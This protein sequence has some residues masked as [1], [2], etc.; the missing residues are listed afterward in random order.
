MSDD[1]SNDAAKGRMNDY[2]DGPARQESFA[3]RADLGFE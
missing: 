3:A 2:G 1:I